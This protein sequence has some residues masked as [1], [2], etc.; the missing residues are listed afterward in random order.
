MKPISSIGP[1]SPLSEK[2]QVG[3]AESD[4]RNIF[5]DAISQLKETE[6]AVQRD[7]ELLATGQIDDLHTLGINTTKAY[8]AER[9]V[10]ELRNRTLD[11]YS[12][13]MRLNI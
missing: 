2:K 1:A 4:F 11:A 13:I 3:Q 7:T 8:L 6:A 10:V 5:E 12:E 9:L